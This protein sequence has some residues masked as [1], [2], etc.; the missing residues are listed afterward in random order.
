MKRLFL[1]LACPLLF[2]GCMSLARI[3]TDPQGTTTFSRYH[4]E[5]TVSKREIDQVWQEALVISG[6]SLDSKFQPP[7]NWC[8]YQPTENMNQYTYGVFSYATNGG[9]YVYNPFIEKIDM[10]IDD[11]YDAPLPSADDVKAFTLGVNLHEDLHAVYKHKYPKSDGNSDHCMMVRSGD[12]LKGSRF[13]EENITHTKGYATSYL[14]DI[15][16]QECLN[17]I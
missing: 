2:G 1:T 12:L 16:E 14:V 8:G 13:I 4:K 5:F 7:L 15:T 10:F 3:T 9:L 6:C 17:G 11:I